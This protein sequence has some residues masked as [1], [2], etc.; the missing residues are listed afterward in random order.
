[1]PQKNNNS[2]RRK[3]YLKEETLTHDIMTEGLEK[4][5]WKQARE[6]IM[7]SVTLLSIAF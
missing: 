7:S 2:V 3:T 5:N 1:M 6:S 4:K